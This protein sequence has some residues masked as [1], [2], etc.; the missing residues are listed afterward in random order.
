M[1]SDIAIVVS[2]KSVRLYLELKNF[3]VFTFLYVSLWSDR[4]NRKYLIHLKFSTN[5]YLLCKIS[6]IAFSVDCLKSAFTAI[7]KSISIHY[8]QW[9][10]MRLYCCLSV[11]DAISV[12]KKFR[13][14][15]N[16][17]ICLCFMQHEL[18]SSCRTLPK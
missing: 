7:H 14:T 6:C 18:C 11:C 15:W 8:S 1:S 2:E 9:R 17:H 12:P 10:E 16:F 4:D 3:L 5:I 13:C